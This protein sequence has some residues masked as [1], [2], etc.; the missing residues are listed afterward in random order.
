MKRFEF[1][2]AI[3]SDR[4]LDYYRGAVQHVIAHCADGQTVQFPAGLLQ[5]FV[6]EGGVHGNFVLTCEETNKGAHLQRL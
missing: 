5:P 2:L 3:S 4:Y 6:T 1:S